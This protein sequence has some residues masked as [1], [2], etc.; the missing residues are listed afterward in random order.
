MENE[1][2]DIIRQLANKLREGEL[3][4][5]EGAWERFEAM[6]AKAVT[7]AASATESIPGSAARVRSIWRPW[8]GVAAAALLAI[9]AGWF[10]MAS[11]HPQP[12]TLTMPSSQIA[13]G[14]ASRPV[15]QGQQSPRDK[16]Q[17]AATSLAT[18]SQPVAAIINNNGE[19]NRVAPLNGNTTSNYE[20]NFPYLIEHAGIIKLNNT[21]HQGDRAAAEAIAQN[22]LASIN[23]D[24]QPGAPGLRLSPVGPVYTLTE[25][26]TTAAL[27]KQNVSN[28]D[29]HQKPVAKSETSPAL[30]R[31]GGEP[32]DDKGYFDVD[33]DAHSGKWDM[34]V[35]VTPAIS[36]NSKLNMGYG[37]SVGYKLSN[38]LSINSGVAY[39]ELSGSKDAG[40]QAS[41]ASG[42]RTLSSIDATA[43]GVNVPLELRYHVSRKI[44]VGTGV[45]AMA[46][47]SDKVERKYAIAQMQTSAFEAKNGQALKPDAM[48]VIASNI[49]RKEVLP[50]DQARSRDFAGFINFSF[51]FKQPLNKSKSL[52][53]EPFISVPMSN[54]L[55]NQNIKMTDGGLRIKLGL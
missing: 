40:P 32:F 24:L 22:A 51:G 26:Q 48:Q 28:T 19:P 17:S 50:E 43:A 41:F 27:P 16:E 1:D 5:K 4:Y 49:E 9:G 31:P 15:K 21:F 55:F 39:T 14:D 20:F 18:N 6:E 7:A 47:L 42:G 8:M 53:I 38:R 25:N 44:Y 12:D 45:S 35:V 3:P 36:N 30:S 54:N 11:H 33:D 13:A 37:V 29:L 34:G 46:V 2:K 10:Y 52:S 23:T